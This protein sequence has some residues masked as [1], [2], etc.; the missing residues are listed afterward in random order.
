[1]ASRGR[2]LKGHHRVVVQQRVHPSDLTGHIMKQFGGDPLHLL[3]PGEWCHLRLPMEYETEL[4]CSTPIFEDPRKGNE[5]ALLWPTGFDQTLVDAI[6]LSMGEMIAVGQLQ[7]RPTVAGGTLF[8]GEW[9][10]TIDPLPKEWLS[11]IFGESSQQGISHVE[12]G[13]IE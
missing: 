4:H 7:Q 5:G 1:M 8:K 10:G 9:L 3:D 2:M 13:A 11:A 12:I 6:K